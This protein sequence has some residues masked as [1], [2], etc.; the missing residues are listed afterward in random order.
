MHMVT[1]ILGYLSL[2]AATMVGGALGAWLF[3]APP[4]RA[5]VDTAHVISGGTTTGGVASPFFT[6]PGLGNI[7]IA[8]GFGNQGEEAAQVL[9]PAGTLSKLRVKLTTENAPTSGTFTLMVRVNGTDTNLT[10]SL[11]EAGTCSA[12]N[13]VKALNN[14]AL[15]AIRVTNT[16]N[17]GA[18]AQAFTYS[19]QFD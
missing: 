1:R 14:N 17:A 5:L 2:A 12:G 7:Y 11:T 18:G 19:M 13:K 10:C 8:T 15:L 9:F 6:A 16:L 4:A 3:A